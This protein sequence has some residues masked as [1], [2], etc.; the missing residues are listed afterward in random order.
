MSDR[1]HSSVTTLPA[2]GAGRLLQLV[3]VLL[4]VSGSGPVRGEATPAPIP[5]ALRPV[6]LPEGSGH[7]IDRWL[8]TTR[9]PVIEDSAF[10]RRVCLDVTGLLP[11]PEQLQV[12]V[13]DPAPDKREALVRDLI[14]DDALY[15]DHWISFWQ[16]LLRDG[17]IDVGST[18]VFQPIT[19]WLWQALESNTPYDVMTRE[20]VNPHG[21]EQAIQYKFNSLAGKANDQGGRKDDANDAAGFVA[22]LQAGLEIPQGDQQWEVQAT[23]NISQVFLGVQMKCATCHDSF[24]DDWTMKDAWGLASI[25][26]EQP[27]EAVRCEI[28]TGTK[29][30]VKFLF[31]EV[32]AIDPDA[33]VAERRTQFTHLLMAKENGRF[34]RTM[35][36]RLWARLMG[37]GLIE[38][39]DEMHRLAFHP[40]LLEWLASDFVEHG[41]DLRHTIQRIV[42]SRAYQMQAVG[43]PAET[44][45]FRGPLAKR[46]TAEQFEDALG[47]LTG[48][49]SRAWIKNGDR[50][51]EALGRPDR[52]TVTTQRLSP[53]ST[54]QSLELMNGAVLHELLYGERPSSSDATAK[55]FEKDKLGNK[56]QPEIEPIEP[57][58][59]TR[60]A[61]MS[62]A[63]QVQHLFEWAVSRPPSAE[64]LAIATEL[65][66]SRTM[67]GDTM[68]MADLVW[69]VTML[70][71]FQWVR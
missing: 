22:G 61:D 64:E 34:P 35:V 63:E 11:T 24:I 53:T 66:Q 51:M 62:S 3:C 56:D 69:A 49:R 43:L 39:V 19:I 41:Y 46:L 15:A 38:P 20:L 14:G 5:L 29:P 33:S 27:L 37:R 7:P 32:G 12:F 40:D 44:D 18:D 65:I 23:Q 25:Y 10:A 50:L 6:Q 55:Q 67:D 54:L 60:Y 8:G 16:D 2:K 42:T 70:P 52:R 1:I 57:P 71:E 59:F 31:A 68:P 36:N 26:S 9:S 45:S 30:P 47:Q 4:I 21:L 58:D 13:C 28:P 48:R 17:K